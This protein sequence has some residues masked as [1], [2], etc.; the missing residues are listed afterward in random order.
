MLLYTLIMTYNKILSG[1]A[2]K[3]KKSLAFLAQKILSQLDESGIDEFQALQQLDF[4]NGGRIA[5]EANL[6]VFK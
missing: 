4:K 6:K 3:S 2:F 1:G 5:I